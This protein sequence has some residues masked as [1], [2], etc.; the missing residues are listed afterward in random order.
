MAAKQQQARAI[1]KAYPLG[2]MQDSA[3]SIRVGGRWSKTAFSHAA[4]ATTYAVA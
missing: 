1:V 2:C 4:L 3:S